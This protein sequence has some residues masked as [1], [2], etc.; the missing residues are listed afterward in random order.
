MQNISTPKPATEH[1]LI[2]TPLPWPHPYSTQRSTAWKPPSRTT[3]T[4]TP[5]GNVTT[6]LTTPHGNTSTTASPPTTS[7]CKLTQCCSFTSQPVPIYKGKG[8][9]INTLPK[10][11][12]FKILRQLLMLVNKSRSLPPL[13]IRIAG[14][15][16]DSLQETNN[17]N[18]RLDVKTVQFSHLLKNL[19][20]S[21][22]KLICLNYVKRNGIRCQERTRIYQ[23]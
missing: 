23:K 11:I 6:T 7:N 9:R 2:E 3:F 4:P 5:Q 22:G 1:G 13:P 15:F 21:N 19:F 14:W 12:K 17:Q 10:N 8:Q 16:Q 20:P 18:F